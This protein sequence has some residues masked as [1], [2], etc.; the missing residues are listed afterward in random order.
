VSPYL[1]DQNF[2]CKRPN[3]I[4]LTDITYI[5]TKEGWLYLAGHRD[6]FS[7]EIV[8]YATGTRMTNSLVCKLLYQAVARKRPGKG[9]IH[10][11]DWG[12]QYCSLSYRKLLK[13]FEIKSSMSRKGNCYDNSPIESFWGILKNELVH[14]H[15]YQSRHC[16]IKEITEFIEVF[17]NRQRT[18]KKLGFLPPIEFE[19][20]YY[21]NKLA[22]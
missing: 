1:V 11:S 15:R 20:Q 21:E 9:L 7:G 18:Q 10:H 8:G 22:A 14:H 17:Y 6:L 5:P 16:A 3:E 13:R 4:W 2:I 12:S 19:N